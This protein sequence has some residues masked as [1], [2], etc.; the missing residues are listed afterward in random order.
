MAV[1]DRRIALAAASLVFVVGAIVYCLQP[2]APVA[3]SPS[4]I[5]R[6]RL[7]Y[8]SEGCIH[9]HSQYAPSAAADVPMSGP[10]ENLDEPHQKHP[11]PTANGRQGPDLAR[12]GARRSALWLKMQLFDPDEVSGSSG[13]PSYA[14]LFRDQKG[15]DLVAY[16]VSLRGPG[17]EGRLDEGQRWHLPP[18]AS[19]AVDPA[20]GLAVYKRYCATCHN[21]DG[22]TRLR[23]QAEFIETPAILTPGVF[24]SKSGGTAESAE[25]NHL[26]QI[27]KFGI[28]NSDMAGHE[29]LTDRD[30]ASLSKWL[31]QVSAEPPETKLRTVN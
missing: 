15:N 25:L 2:S 7:V 5:E 28:P 13:M 27:I 31:V 10:V 4:A 30:I 6:G 14:A 3:A 8:T 20:D 11:S 16:L 22:V 9:C 12:I 24:S 1:R 21:S 23:W 17:A 26:A 29:S 19:A 18:D